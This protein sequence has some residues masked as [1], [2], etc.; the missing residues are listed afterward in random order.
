MTL[1]PRLRTERMISERFSDETVSVLS[2]ITHRKASSRSARESFCEEWRNGVSNVP[3]LVSFATMKNEAV[4][5]RLKS[6]RLPDSDRSFIA[7]VGKS[8][9][10][11]IKKIG[12]YGKPNFL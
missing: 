12:R 4:V 1:L 5:K 9:G 3:F 11:W 7:I 10:T 6:R 2:F 8:C